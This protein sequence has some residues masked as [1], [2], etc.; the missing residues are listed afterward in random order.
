MVYQGCGERTCQAAGGSLAFS[1][2]KLLPKG[3]SLADLLQLAV[4]ISL[5][6]CARMRAA[7]E[8]GCGQI[9]PDPPELDFFFREQDEP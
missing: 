4:G 5:E 7:L 6:D 8:E 2:K 1:T 3:V 9:D